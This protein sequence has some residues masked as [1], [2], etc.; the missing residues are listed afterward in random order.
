MLLR[1]WG[2][3]L[4]VCFLIASTVW[5][6]SSSGT[7]EGV[8]QDPTGAV[9]PGAQVRLI[10]S[11]TGAIVREITTGAEGTFA[12]PLL[13]PMTY[14]VEATAAGFKKLVRSGIALRVDDVLNLRLSLDVG[15]AT[16]SVTVTASAELL[17]QTTNTV[18]QVIDTRT[19]Q[20]LPLNGR[21]YLQLGNLTA[22]TVPNSRTRDQ[23]FSAYGNRGL[24][25]AFLLDGARNQNYL[26][27][28]DN[29]ARDAMRP[30]LEAVSEFKV[31][32]SNYSAEYGASAG[33]V[34]TVVT[35]SGGNDLHGS[36]FEFLR[37]SAVDARDFFL[38]ASATKPL[39]VEHQFGGS[40]GGRIV[41]NRAWWHAAYQRTHIS[42]GNTSSGVVPQPAERNGIFGIQVFDPLTTR[43]NPAGT[44]SI[45]DPFPNNTI[46]TN[47]FD[48]LGKS[49]ID[50]YPNPNQTGN[51]NYFNN[52]LTG[53]RT[54]N[55][56]V[57]GDMRISDKDTLFARWSLDQ[58]SFNALPL[59]PLGTQTGVVRDVPA[60]S[61]G[62]GY[63][64]ILSTA[65]V[66]E[67]RFAYN[68]VGLTQDATQPLEDLIP[69][70]LAPT[71]KSS[72][73]T[74]NI[75]GYAGIGARP[76]NFDNVPVTK[77]SYVYNVSDNISIVHGKMTTKIG[78][79]FQEIYA[80]TFAT[81]DG[82]G[83]FGFTGVF[84]QNPQRRP[85]SG[86][87]I[88]DLL[89]GIPNNIT[90]GTPSD[91]NE[92]TR[93]YYFYVQHDWNI[94]P[95]FTLNAGLR[96]EIT[97]PYWDD[98][99]RLS[100]LVI[101]SGSQ[102]YG[103]Y[104]IAGD[105]RVPRAIQSTDRNNFAPRLGFAYKG[106]RSTVIR[107]GAGIFYAQ[108]EGFGV[109]QRMTNNPPFVGFGGY[110]IVSDQ[111]NISSTIPLNQALP[112]R[113]S[114]PDPKTYKLD[115]RN[116][117]AIRSWPLRY[118]IPY[119]QQWNLNIQKEIVKNVVWEIGYVGNHGVKL[120]GAYEGNQ[121]TPGPGAVNTRRPLNSTTSGSI[122]RVEPWVNS[123]YHG[124]TTKLERRYANGVNFLAVY[125]FGRA[126]DM[127]TSIDL[128]DGC[129]N[130]GGSGS[131]VDARNRRLNYGLS[132]SHMG[133]RF[134]L[135]GLWE[136]PFGNGRRF[137][138]QGPAARIAGGWALSGITTL[139]SGIPMT[140]NLNFDNANTGNV[141]WPNRNAGGTLD[142]PT[143][144]RWFDTSAFA[145]PAQYVQG[146]AGRN[147]L[148]GPPTVSTDVSLQRNFRLPIRDAGRLEFRAE[149]FNL[150]NT[151][152]LGQPGVTLGNPAFG[153][154]GGTARNN[155]QMQ[156]GLKLLF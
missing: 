22:G 49:L 14:T 95:R 56:T 8:V 96:Y 16:D 106:P 137:L 82:R 26:R 125:T 21:N 29:R 146:N 150:F 40:L 46:P 102:L 2:S 67:V 136:L 11:E 54:H 38:P 45:R 142:N 117:A 123:T 83:S 135:S 62:L 15:T 131:I 97:A 155:R 51:I 144:G 19:M 66:N 143:V 148:T 93:N 58:A 132:D 152:Q 107:G 18:G 80:P 134:V 138:T 88:A 24:Q 68:H 36:G 32:T 73:P 42:Q 39:F 34:V 111:L 17:E 12:A 25:N 116:T 63:T 99:G 33:A 53:T 43:A 44:G 64:R 84:T 74:I 133:Q 149:A 57:R 28:L 112:A 115:P 86:S 98:N 92:R 127:Q 37:N 126:L 91:A 130:S 47:R 147:I 4:V 75:S 94:T 119:V 70:A 89:L 10:G 60:R 27:G 55:A 104:V 118:T 6:Q 20:Q 122:L 48:R 78:F 79:D 141:N 76:A 1:S 81:L 105:S 71:T 7:I 109:S 110:S 61:I 154:I 87:S 69:G 31:Q 113:P 41:R 59:L 151:P 35:R 124:I 65:I 30:S 120:Y 100:N 3:S 145:F 140:L 139:S 153:I 72:M 128:C 5:A 156:M 90:V 23:T 101:D 129:T 52:P 9:V 50:R 77:D 103:Q 108:D 114:A 85:G 13:R 121:P